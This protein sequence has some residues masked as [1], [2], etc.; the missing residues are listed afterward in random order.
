MKQRLFVDHI[1]VFARAG[2]GGNGVVHFRR[3]KFVPRGGPDG[4]DGGK[5]GDVILEVKENTDNLTPFL[6]KSRLLAQSGE[7]NAGGVRVSPI[8]VETALNAHPQITECAAAEVRVKADT[9]LIAAFYVADTELD[10]Q[11]LDHFASQRLARYK[12][13]RIYHRIDALPKGANGKIL[14]KQLRDSYEDTHGQA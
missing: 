13:P 11:D 5:G 6:Y 3:E 12:A 9:T 14:R 1:R 8:E 2:D 4:G 10:R 7:L